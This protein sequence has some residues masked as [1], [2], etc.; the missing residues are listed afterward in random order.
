MFVTAAAFS[1][2]PDI[3]FD[4]VAQIGATAIINATEV[5]LDGV[6]PDSLFGNPVTDE[7]NWSAHDPATLANNLRGMNL[8][9]FTGNGQTGPLDPEPNLGGSSLESLVGFDNQYFQQRLTSLGIPDYFDDY[10]PGTHSWPYWTRDLQQ[11]IGSIMDTFAH[12]PASP[13]SVTYT[14][15]QPEYSEF[16]WSVAIDRTAEEFSSLEDADASGFSLAGSGSAVVK[17]P[18]MYQPGQ[19]YS[20]IFAG[21]FFDGNATA[22]A[23]RSG[24]LTLI[25]PL[26]LANPYQQYTLNAAVAGGTKTFTTSVTIHPER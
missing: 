15:T 16:G 22:M 2:A 7:I 13:S 5:G 17:T 12:P 18:A 26:G 3:A 11:S 6:P 24:R 8:L 1:G 4:P 19:Q 21:P 23:D 20:V 9:L 14:S 25:V 10:G